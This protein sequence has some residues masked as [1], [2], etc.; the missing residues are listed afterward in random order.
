MKYLTHFFL[1]NKQQ[2]QIL[3]FA[4]PPPYCY[5]EKYL[6]WIFIVFFLR[7]S[8]TG[9]Q[10]PNTFEN[11]LLFFYNPYCPYRE[12]SILKWIFCSFFSKSITNKIIWFS[13][14][15]NGCHKAFF[16][17]AIPLGKMYKIFLS[18]LKE[19]CIPNI[20]K[21]IKKHENLINFLMFGMQFSF[22]FERNILYIFPKGI[23]NKKMLCGIHFESMKIK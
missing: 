15:Q 11:I 20:I 21:S 2:H 13:L 18:K 8:R 7:C 6:W 3:Y 9:L 1:F 5:I 14:T 16:L 23:A 10:Y 12:S 19:K 4:P 22:N 17:F